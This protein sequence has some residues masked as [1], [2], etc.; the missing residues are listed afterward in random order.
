MNVQ[1]VPYMLLLLLATVISFILAAYSFLKR[2]IPAARFFGML[3]LG[4]GIW[5]LF[6]LFE[7]VN[8]SLR[9]KELYFALK[10]LGVVM[11]PASLLAFT[12]E[13]TG[14][15]LRRVLK[16]LPL[17]AIEPLVTLGVLV[18][19]SFHGLFY[20]NARLEIGMGFI[21]MAFTPQFWFYLNTIYSLM[22]GVVAVILIVNYARNE[23]SFRRRQILVF[24]SGGIVPIL[25]LFFVVSGIS[26]LPAIDYTSVA[27]VSSLPF[28]ALSVFRYRLLDV[29][30]E[31][32][33]LAIEFM[34]DSVIVINRG[35]RILDL[36][37]AAQELFNVKAVEVIG[38]QLS[39]FLPLTPELVS[40]ISRPERFQQDL[41]LTRAGEQAQF[42]LR[43][44]RL[45]SWYGR[46][47]GRLVLLHDVTETR[48]LEQ[49]LRQAKDAAEEATRAKSLFLASMS[50]EIRT[51]LNAVIG[52]T[53][54]L[55]DTP[56]TAEQQE[57][58]N[59]IRAGSDTLLT[60]IND[61]LD[62][63]KIEAGRME[64]ET[65]V[66]SLHNCI[67]DAVDILAPQASAKG[68][69]LVFQPAADLPDIV[70]GDPTRLRQVLVNLLS[71]AVKFTEKGE[72]VVSAL[73]EREQK[74]KYLLHLSVADTGIGI[75][76]DS[77][78][79]VFDTFTQADASI[80]RRYGGSGLG[81]T[82]SSRLVHI[83]GGQ[84]WAE[85][86]EGKGSTF[87]FTIQVEPAERNPEIQTE[88][89]RNGLAGKQ[90][91]VVDDTAAN[92]AIL[93]S[94]LQ[95][96]GAQ[97]EVVE[98]ANQALSWLQDHGG[99]DLVLLDMNLPEMNGAELARA[100]HHQPKLDQIPLVLLSSL[101]QRSTETDRRLFAA[102]QN[103]PIRPAQLHALL[104]RLLSPG[105]SQT[106]SPAPR[107]SAYVFDVNFAASHP[108]HILL[109]EDNPV[110]Q[111]VA[112]GF[113]ERLGYTADTAAN[114]LE[115]VE[116]VRRQ[117]YDLVLMDVRMPELDGLQATR[118]IRTSLPL[119]RQ[120]RIVAMTAFAFQEDLEDCLAAGMDDFLSKPIQ[121]DRLAAVLEKSR[122]VART[123]S[124]DS[125]Q[126]DIQPSTILDGLGKDSTEII[127]L[128][129]H[130]LT[131]KYAMLQSA[132]QERDI[133]KV[134]DCAHQL[135]TD[136]K[137]LGAN[138]FSDF[139]LTVERQAIDGAFPDETVNQKIQKLFKQIQ[140]SYQ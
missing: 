18:T 1:V 7:V 63:S 120:P 14:V 43:S 101:A 58:V 52:M 55:Q 48:R 30:P 87:H 17:L 54:L 99:A 71:N 41:I 74:G 123:T 21:V 95:A 103:K 8:L 64:L 100:I 60:S 98:T 65:Q 113:L 5:S 116:A 127:K 25:V 50:H 110:N 73:V 2:T 10:Y 96:W 6:Y 118:Q 40:G 57:Y 133:E 122:V 92:R 66:F 49:S 135:K 129:L 46:P 136:A 3:A 91:L 107:P 45:A 32:R 31:A 90:I 78:E 80:A 42:E 9:L 12:M 13:F 102:V 62:F 128:L 47:A 39:Q 131:N 81:L 121:P 117:P 67:G 88:T 28:L 132:L 106:D 94:F 124:M 134:R 44:F 27:M 85:S 76:S 4:I 126:A 70:L 115:A 56:L 84:I 139:M 38:R 53:S 33:D 34:D 77:L 20:I 83:M 35:F 23:T 26:R 109:A 89:K 104:V 79:R 138:Q 105:E 68:I 36:N 11:V 108:L 24:M 112:V 140:N 86:E 15:P 130:N 119:D 59:T 61:I 75:P 125:P 82:I 51:P 114:G 111:R 93:L 37:P 19:N 16:W 137:Y 69:E 72:V 29:V 97:V 22:I